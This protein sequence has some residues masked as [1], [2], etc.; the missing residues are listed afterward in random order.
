[1]IILMGVFF[2]DNT[3]VDMLIKSSNSTS[4]VESIKEYQKQTSIANMNIY[5]V[6]MTNKRQK[7]LEI[8]IYVFFYGFVALITAICVANI[9]NTISTLLI[10]HIKSYYKY[11]N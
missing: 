6:A 11:S 8:F 4:L 7:Q 1:M 2:Y 5:D 10:S 3:N 9:F